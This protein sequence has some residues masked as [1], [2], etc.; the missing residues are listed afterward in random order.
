[1]FQISLK[2]ARVNAELTLEQ[3]AEKLGVTKQ[4][5]INWEKGR[6]APKPAEFEYL[7]KIYAAPREFIF[8]P[9]RFTNS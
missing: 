1:M 2:A 6:T 8:L 5:M 9:T 7:C 4:T 3:A